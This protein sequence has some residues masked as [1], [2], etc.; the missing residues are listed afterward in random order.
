MDHWGRKLRA[1]ILGPRAARMLVR[2]SE[3]FLAGSYLEQAA[4]QGAAVPAWALLN[5][6]AHGDLVH[7]KTVARTGAG[8][9]RWS[10]PIGWSRASRELAREVTDLVGDD[11]EMLATVQLSVLIPFELEFIKEHGDDGDLSAA[12]AWGRAALHSV[13]W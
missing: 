7:L 10:L 13:S 2:E 12:V 8:P 6:V 3:A 11:E 5:T 9:L 4:R 1:R